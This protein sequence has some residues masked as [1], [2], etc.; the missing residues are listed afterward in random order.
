MSQSLVSAVI[1][2]DTELIEVAPAAQNA[3]NYNGSSAPARPIL[4]PNGHWQPSSDSRIGR[5]VSWTDFHG[6]NL[7]NVHEFEPRYVDPVM[8]T[9]FWSLKCS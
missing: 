5:N 6:K 9:S 4:R 7:H 8:I 3:T 1:Q 2:E